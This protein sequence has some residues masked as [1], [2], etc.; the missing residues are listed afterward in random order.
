[1]KLNFADLINKHAGMP[2]VV[3]LHGPSLDPHREKIED[4]QQNEGYLRLSV[5][6]WYDFFKEK[7]DYWVVSNTEYTIYNSIL[8]NFFWDQYNRFE[9]NVFNRYNVPLLYNDTADLTDAVFVDEQLKCD[10]LSYDTKHFQQTNCVDILKSFKEHYLENKNFDFKQFGN[11]TMMWQPLTTEG[12]NCDP[13][14]A[15]FAGAWSRNRKCCHKLNPNRRTIQEE[16]QLLSGYEQ[17]MGPGVSVGFFA[18][19]FAILM[20][21]NPIY[22]AGMNL[23]Y[24]EG[25]AAPAATNYKHRINRGAIGH[26]KVIYNETIRDDLRILKESAALLGIDIINLNKNSW[27]DTLPLGELP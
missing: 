17:H 1:M 25:Y 5:N 8:P 26:W 27:F 11:N 24:T 18:L 2:C 21:C 16:L 6:Q 23:D 22:V 13:A 3:A 14:W 7:P 9:K 12:T 4:L 19:S 10:Y 20:G 15:T